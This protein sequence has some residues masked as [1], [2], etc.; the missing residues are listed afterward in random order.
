M[1]VETCFQRLYFVIG[2][3]DSEYDIVKNMWRIFVVVVLLLL[4]LL[5]SYLGV[6][7]KQNSKLSQKDGFNSYTGVIGYANSGDDIVVFHQQRVEGPSADTKCPQL[8]K[9]EQRSE[10]VYYKWISLCYYFQSLYLYL[11]SLFVCLF[12]R[13][14]NQMYIGTIKMS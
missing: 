5:V 8:A 6:K 12:V 7:S 10:L 1:I 4:L 11:I 14:W 2:Y 13:F 3:A 9:H